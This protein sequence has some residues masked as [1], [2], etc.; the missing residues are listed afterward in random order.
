MCENIDFMI[1]IVVSY[2]YLSRWFM[3]LYQCYYHGDF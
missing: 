2:R 1:I 3:A